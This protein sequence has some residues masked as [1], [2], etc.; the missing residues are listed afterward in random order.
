MPRF[1]NATYLLLLFKFVLSERLSNN[2][3]GS[4]LLLFLEFI[5]KYSLYIITLLNSLY[6]YIHLL[7]I[8]FVRYKEC[9][10]WRSSFSRFTD[11]L[12]AFISARGIDK[13]WRICL[14]LKISSPSPW[15]DLYL[16]LGTI[17]EWS[18]NSLTTFSRNL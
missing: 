14:E 7:V 6:S 16:I 17:L 5:N 9:M 1:D 10:I 8:S 18:L 12:P 15:T 13:L 11:V 2:I 3:W 4:D